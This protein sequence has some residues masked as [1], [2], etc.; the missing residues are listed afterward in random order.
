MCKRQM[1]LF[2][3]TP[4]HAPCT[5][6]PICTATC[7]ARFLQSG[8]GFL[9]G[10]AF[11]RGS[12]QLVGHS[13]NYMTFVEDGGDECLSCVCVCVGRRKQLNNF[14]RGKTVYVLE[15]RRRQNAI[16][17][18]FSPVKIQLKI[19]RFQLLFTSLPAHGNARPTPKCNRFGQ[20]KYSRCTHRHR[21]AL[22]GH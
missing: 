8:F 21:R 20:S 10:S 2:A 4:G 3:C 19:H 17:L 18:T 1:R 7:A 22:S 6:P 13:V 9:C 5:E 12:L 11:S 16:P 14:L 15:H